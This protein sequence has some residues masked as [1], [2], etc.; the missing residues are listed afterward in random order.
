MGILDDI[1]LDAGSFIFH[2]F[3]ST[4]CVYPVGRQAT[5]AT[6]ATRIPPAIPPRL[7]H[8]VWILQ[9]AATKP[10]STAGGHVVPK[11]TSNLCCKLRR[12]RMT[13]HKYQNHVESRA[14]TWKPGIHHSNYVF[15]STLQKAVIG[16]GE[17]PF[18]QI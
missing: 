16:W 9:Q 15:L 17:A 2:S 8:A 18:M 10:F 6:S 7:H 1:Q 5:H 4:I 12:T 3:I 14:S 13:H 11:S